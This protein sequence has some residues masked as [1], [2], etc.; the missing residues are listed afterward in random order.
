MRLES[1]RGIALLTVMLLVLILTALGILSITV[2]GWGKRV[3]GLSGSTESSAAAAESCVGTSA[4][5]I[6]QTITPG[7]VVGVPAAALSNAI[8]P[9][10]VPQANAPTLLAEIK[11][12]P[13][14]GT[15]APSENNPDV[16]IGA[17]AV[18]N[19]VQAVNNYAVT[20]DI[21]RMYA[22]QQAG[23]GMQQFAG[24]EGTG[25][26]AASGGTNVLYQIDCYAANVATGTISRVT[27]VYSCTLTG[28]SCQKKP[29]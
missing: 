5:I 18:P 4:N 15:G 7:L 22:Q 29:L 28:E 2:T 12:Q 25:Q 8:P 26:G 11:G 21:D 20:G 1:E 23:T 16:A 3:A 10:P 6:Q 24:Y 19:V 17:G 14:P 27:A 9:G 13:L